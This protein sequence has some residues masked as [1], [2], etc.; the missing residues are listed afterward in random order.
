[1]MVK[2]SGLS[3]ELFQTTDLEIN[4]ALTVKE[5]K[6]ELFRLQPGLS[7]YTV[8]LAVNEKLKGD[9]YTLGDGDRILVFHPY[10]GG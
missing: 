10:A 6:N 1:M 4:P 7:S 8:L 5:V 3:A 9:S 2:L